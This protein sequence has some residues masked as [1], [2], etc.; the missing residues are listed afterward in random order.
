M[1]KYLNFILTVVSGLLLS[2]AWPLRD[3]VPLIFIALMPL[4]W[5]EHRIANGGKG[6]LFWLAFLAFFIWNVPK[7]NASLVTVYMRRLLALKDSPAH[8]QRLL[9]DFEIA[10]NKDLSVSKTLTKLGPMLG[11]MGTLIP[12]IGR[13]HV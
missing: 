13:A 1:K 5:A 11:L 9:A 12:K 6:R 10:A 7:G 3:F 8:V 2:A 4:L